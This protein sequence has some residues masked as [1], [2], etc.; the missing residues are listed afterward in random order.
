MELYE[1]IKKTIA[2][3]AECTVEEVKDESDFQNDLDMDSLEA[4]E[5]LHRIEKKYK[6]K[7]RDIPLENVQNLKDIY[8]LCKNVIGD[9]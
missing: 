2:E 4:I 9:L 3:I 5:I 8:E 1:F 6:T 7:L